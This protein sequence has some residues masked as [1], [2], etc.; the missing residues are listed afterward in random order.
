MG[1]AIVTPFVAPAPVAA[2]V[3]GVDELPVRRGVSVGHEIARALPSEHR[4]ARDAPRRALEVDLA[5]EEVEE[6]RRVVEA[7]GLAP[8]APERV[9]EETPRLLDAEEVVLIRCLLVRVAGG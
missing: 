3:G 6:Q 1:H 9:V 2:P 5:F 8:S 7:P 4:V